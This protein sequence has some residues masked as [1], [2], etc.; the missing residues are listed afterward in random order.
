MRLYTYQSLSTIAYICKYQIYFADYN[1]G[2]YTT[3]E[4]DR[5]HFKPLY[6]WMMSQYNKRR[7]NEFSSAPVWWYTD[8]KE[9]VSKFSRYPVGSI[10][11]SAD[12]PEKFILLHDADLW[13]EGPLGYYHLGFRG[14]P[15]L[16]TN[17]WE[18]TNYETLSDN[19]YEAYKNN[20]LAAEETWNEIFNIRRKDSIKQRIHA[21]TPFIAIEWLGGIN[22]AQG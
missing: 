6:Q 16:L 13:E 18:G 19:L 2:F 5:N 1:K 11:F 10:L 21:I 14:H 17:D 22:V 7:N 20:R 9:A 12:V 4:S 3:D 8:R 15:M